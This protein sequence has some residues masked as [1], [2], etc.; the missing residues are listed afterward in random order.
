MPP[1]DPSV[2]SEATLTRLRRLILYTFL[3][4]TLGT[5]AEL[6]L[7][8][9]YEDPWQWTP[10]ALLGVGFVL[11]L[12]LLRH[13]GPFRSFR[14]L[15]ALYVAGG[16]LG[17]YLHFRGNMEFELE[18]TASMKGWALVWESLTGATPTL[19]PGAM[20]L[21]GVLGWMYTFRHPVGHDAPH[22]SE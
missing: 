11:G 7:I 13:G 6:G 4:G 1:P 2:R 14:G 9:H 21:L 8:G 18:M 19:A 17:L 12:W 10:L 3:A 22:Q 20:I 16:L 5:G 15:M